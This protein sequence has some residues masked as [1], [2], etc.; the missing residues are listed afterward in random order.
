M[1]KTEIAQKYGVCLITFNKWLEEFTELDI[2]PGQRILTPA[3]VRMIYQT[4]GEP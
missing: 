3:Q 4:I 1:G 2:K